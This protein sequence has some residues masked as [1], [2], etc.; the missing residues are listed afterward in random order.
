MVKAQL[1][2]LV[3]KSLQN[4]S[5]KLKKDLQDKLF[6]QGVCEDLTTRGLEIVVNWLDR[7]LEE[8]KMYKCV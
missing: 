1:S 3:A 2:A 6:E 7:E 5:T 4:C 8:D